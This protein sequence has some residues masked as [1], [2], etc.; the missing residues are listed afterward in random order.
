M[1]KKYVKPCIEV[2]VVCTDVSIMNPESYRIYDNNGNLVGGGF[3]VEN[4]MPFDADEED[5]RELSNRSNN[6]LWE[7]D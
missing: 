3:I 4:E 5:L 7:I 6:N 1:K 2:I